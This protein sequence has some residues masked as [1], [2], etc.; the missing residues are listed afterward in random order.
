MIAVD[1]TH[2][3]RA[4]GHG[5]TSG[6]LIGR[7]RHWERNQLQRCKRS[8]GRNRNASPHW[9]TTTNEHGWMFVLKFLGIIFSQ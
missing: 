1:K 6:P 8:N 4:G 2:A 9:S 3:R 7:G 5:E